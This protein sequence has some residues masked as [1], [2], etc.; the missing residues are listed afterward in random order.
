[1]KEELT[2]VKPPKI[3]GSFADREK[4]RNINISTLL[5]T[6]ASKWV[7]KKN[8]YSPDVHF[9]K[10]KPLIATFLLNKR[11]R[12]NAD[13]F[14]GLWRRMEGGKTTYNAKLK[15]KQHRTATSVICIFIIQQLKRL[16]APSISSLLCAGLD[17]KCS[18][19]CLLT[20]MTL[21]RRRPLRPRGRLT[22]L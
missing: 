4:G 16:M 13:Q 9:A 11:R 10:V 5:G 8:S 20:E 22:V 3:S 2:R 21:S 17:Q 15:E 1:M 14:T 6:K 12:R 7:K 18:P 19:L